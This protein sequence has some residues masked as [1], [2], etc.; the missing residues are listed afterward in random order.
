[1][2]EMST[3][4]DLIRLIYNETDR[5]ETAALLSAIEADP[6]LKQEFNEFLSL[7]GCMDKQTKAPSDRSLQ[8]VLSHIY[9]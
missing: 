2:D 1:M 5:Q 6:N 7:K 4:T 8:T 9:I 3:Q